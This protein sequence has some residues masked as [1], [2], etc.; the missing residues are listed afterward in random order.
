MNRAAPALAGFV[1]GCAGP[2]LS[3]PWHAAA[4][5]PPNLLVLL[6]DDVGIDQVSSWPGADPRARTPNL[7]R[8]IARGMRF[9][10]AWAAPTC[11]PTRAELLTGRYGRRTGVGSVIR[12]DTDSELPLTE[13]TLAGAVRE[14]GYA[15]SAVGKWH[16]A[17]MISPTGARHPVAS[18]FDWYA[19]SMGNLSEPTAGE[20]GGYYHWRRIGP[21]GVDAWCDTYATTSTVD[22]AVARIRAMPEPWLLYVAFNAGHEPFHLPP[23]ALVAERPAVPAALDVRYRAAVEALDTELGRLLDGLGTEAGRTV[24]AV[25]SDNGTPEPVYGEGADGEEVD[26]KNSWSELGI[27]VPMAIVGAGIP[28]G[29]TS[30][31]MVHAVDLWPTLVALAGLDPAALPTAGPLD[32]V[33]LAPLLT[34]AADQVRDWMYTEKFLPNG[35]GDVWTEDWRIGRDLRFKLAISG[36]GPGD[37]TIDHLYDLD[38]A[39]DAVDLLAVGAP[40]LEPAAL[41]AWDD[42]HTRIDAQFEAMRADR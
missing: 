9:T 5:R 37:H 42:L 15:T 18:G 6:I 3:G 20:Y 14:A 17:T 33:S 32:G 29:T 7:D 30:D 26:A 23:A 27:R 19:G 41:A 4:P 21:D 25:A 12:E 10:S 16:L 35:P 36:H 13:L 39:G 34:G 28:A 1:A 2:A 40:P 22:D 38:G 31:A 24:I 8:L 11:S